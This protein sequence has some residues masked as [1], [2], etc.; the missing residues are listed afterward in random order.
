MPHNYKHK[1]CV[2]CERAF[3]ADQY[4]TNHPLAQSIDH[5]IA[6]SIGGNHHWLNKVY[7]C[8]DCNVLKG[9]STLQQF[10]ERCIDYNANKKKYRTITPDLWETIIIN[11]ENLKSFAD[12]HG[13]KLYQLNSP[14]RRLYH[15]EEEKEYVPRY[16]T[17]REINKAAKKNNLTVQE[18]P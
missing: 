16:P 17:I 3:L 12:R 5:I 7:A 11:A 8:R 1:N 4:G 18:E 9:N 10:I 13:H 6:L 14:Y 15:Y 2:Y